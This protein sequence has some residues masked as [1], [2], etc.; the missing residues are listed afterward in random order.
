[1][2]IRENEEID[3]RSK[4]NDRSEIEDRSGVDHK[5]EGTINVMQ[6]TRGDMPWYTYMVN[7][8]F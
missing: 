6:K 1:M 7:G 8:S 5:R 4:V 2:E 3:G